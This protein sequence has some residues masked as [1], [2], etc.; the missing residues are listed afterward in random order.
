M[1]IE[2][3]LLEIFKLEISLDT[4][5]STDFKDFM[6]YIAGEVKDSVKADCWRSNML[7]NVEDAPGIVS[8]SERLQTGNSCI[9]LVDN[10]ADL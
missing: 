10:N 5:R 2:R 6:H 4:L 8:T 7:E 1:I 3:T 9:S